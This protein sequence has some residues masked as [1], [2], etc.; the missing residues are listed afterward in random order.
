[1][2]GKARRLQPAEKACQAQLAA[3]RRQQVASADHV[4]DA[5]FDVVGHHRELVRP[6]S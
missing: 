2:V 6:V 3:G 4:G 5:L 1:V